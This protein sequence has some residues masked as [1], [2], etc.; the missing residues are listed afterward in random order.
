MPLLY[1]DID[2]LSIC[3]HKTK[4]IKHKKSKAN[5]TQAK[6]LEMRELYFSHYPSSKLIY[7]DNGKPLFEDGAIHISVSDSHDIKIVALSEARFALDLEKLRTKNYIEIAEH[8]FHRSEYLFLMACDTQSV[9]E[10][11]FILW[12]LKE[13]FLKFHGCSIFDIKK[14]PSFDILNNRYYCRGIGDEQVYVFK[15]YRVGDDFI[16]SLIF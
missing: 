12:T 2:K 9:G 10:N 13:A 6:I 8:Y 3:P 14:A 11:F 7:S 4:N 1:V 5:S 16:L 15:T